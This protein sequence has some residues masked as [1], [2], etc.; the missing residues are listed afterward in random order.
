MPAYKNQKK[1][2]Q[3]TNEFKVRAVKLTH[4]SGASVKGVADSL[5]IHPFMLSRWRKEYREG[6]IVADKR[7]KVGK[8][9]K[10]L[11]ENERV[12]ML[13]K[14]VADLKEEKR[15]VKK[16]ATVSRGGTQERFRFVAKH[17]ERYGVRRLCRFLKV[18][19]SGFYAWLKR[20]VSQRARSDAA[21]TEQ[22]KRIFEVNR[23]TYG[24]PRVHQA[25]KRQGV[26]VGKKRVERLM[27][28]AGLKAR[29][30]R[31]YRKLAGLHRFYQRAPNLR[32]DLPKPTAPNQ[33]WAADLTYIRVGKR[34][35]YLAAVI[36]LYSRRIVG[37]SLGK[38]KTVSL[39]RASLQMALRN[40]KPEPGLIFHTDRGV[41]YRAHE[42]QALL[43]KHGIQASAN[44]PGMC[45]DNAEMESFFHT[46][47]GELIKKR[48]FYGEMHLR[49]K[50]TGYI[51]HFYNRVR[52]HSS[53]NYLSPVEYEAMI[54]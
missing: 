7:K 14:Q 41:E 36:D 23:E 29:V 27:R 10:T 47:K 46:L 9:P 8:K 6:K 18:S 35:L 39:T 28:E 50:L 45:T 33:H 42:I 21:L 52:L 11:S 54:A 37:C 22:I 53:L 34:W 49:D 3:Y 30:T 32:K 17:R 20:G 2:R 5:D 24:S 51:Q 12:R 43:K 19:A 44:R 38:Q 13:E 16:V 26:H 40:R 15:S 4:L 31:V 1:T 25:L 48:T